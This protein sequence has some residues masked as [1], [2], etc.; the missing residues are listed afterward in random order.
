MSCAS[1]HMNYRK[2]HQTQH[3]NGKQK[4]TNVWKTQQAADIQIEKVC[5]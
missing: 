3:R 4:Q 2:N 5:G 1:L